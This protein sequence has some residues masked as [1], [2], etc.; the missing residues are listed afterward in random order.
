MYLL[1]DEKAVEAFNSSSYGD[2]YQREMTVAEHEEGKRLY[3]EAAGFFK[4]FIGQAWTI[5]VLERLLSKV[6]HNSM[7]DLM[8]RT[9]TATEVVNDELARY[10]DVYVS[11]DS[12]ISILVT[13]SEHNVEEDVVGKVHMYSCYNQDIS[14]LDYSY[15][16]LD[17]NTEYQVVTADDIANGILKQLD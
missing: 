14:G 9:L 13:L 6:R 8:D 17:L 4:E 15:E 5:P 11:N 10:V 7:Y 3:H 12:G 2:V 16:D 1:A